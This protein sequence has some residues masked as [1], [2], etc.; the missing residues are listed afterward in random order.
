MGRLEKIVEGDKQIFIV[1]Y[2]DCKETEM[3]DLQLDLKNQVLN[4]NKPVMVLAIFNDKSYVTPKFM[5]A[6]ED[7]T[8][9]TLHLL[10]KQVMVGL[11]DTKKMILKGYNFLFG[12]N[13]KAFDTR[14]AAIEF[15]L[16][17]RT[18]DR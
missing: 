18:S 7:A 14:E 4:L 11:S 16:D 6:A 13:I 15:L 1:D 12:K 5:R 17:D 9:D 3:I 10:E 8:R 2:S